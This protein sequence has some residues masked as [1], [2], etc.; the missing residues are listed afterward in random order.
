MQSEFD[1]KKFFSDEE[2]RLAFS[3]ALDLAKKA[4][5][6][7]EAEFTDFLDME[8][9]SAFTEKLSYI[10][11][12]NI[13]VFGGVEDTERRIIGFF[14]DFEDADRSKFPIKPILIKHSPK[15]SKSPGHRDYLGAL[16]GLG[17]DRRKMG[18]IFV[19]EGCALAF[20]SSDIAE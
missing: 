3:R 9:V 6:Y 5:R 14:P 10:D 7:Y 8:K 15:F 18:D 20:V 4:S 11:G 17:I 13:D 2:E 16:I 19:L 12:I 1:L